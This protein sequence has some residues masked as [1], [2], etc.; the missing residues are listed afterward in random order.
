[1]LR[2]NRLTSKY[3]FAF[4]ICL[5]GCAARDP[6]VLTPSTPCR[7]WVYCLEGTPIPHC[8][9]I[10][11]DQLIDE[12]R[13]WHLPELVDLGL[14]NSRQTQRSWA[15]TRIRASEYGLSLADFYP[16]ISFSGYIEAVRATTYFG[17]SRISELPG[18]Q[19]IVVNEFRE[20][21]P[22]FSLAYLIFDWGT[23]NARSETFRQR[24][25]SANWEFNREIQTVIRQITGDYYSYVGN[26]GL[27][28]AA[29]ANLKDAQTLYDATHKKY[30]LGIVDKS[31]DL[32][33]LTQ[34]SKQQIQFLQAQQLLETSYAQL[35]AD[36]GIPSTIELNIFGQFE[37]GEVIFPAECTVEQCVEEA[38]MS[39]PDLFASYSDMQST[40]AAVSA[41]KRDKLPKVSLQAAGSRIYY[42]D[43]ENDGNDYGAMISLDYPIF[44]G[45]W[46]EN[47][48]RSASSRYC[49]AKADFEQLQIE[50]VK[51]VVIAHRDL[52]IAVE[53]LKVNRVYVDAAAES[54]RATLMQ[55]EAGVVDITTV[56]NAF[57]SLADARYSLVEAQKVWYTSI[58][59]LAYAIGILGKGTR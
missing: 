30:S 19:D 42:Q 16:E 41:A 25:L 13:V 38:L 23:R 5:A 27:Q 46:Y 20:Y 54:Y 8:Q 17:S 14:K 7:E 51:E 22:S 15:E 32:I 1:M 47:R 35:V 10:D 55:F 33:A 11:D 39:R 28:E 21:A 2:L 31:T 3:F 36:L 12:E 56:V 18:I 59:N 40:E 57:T 29:E 58:A 50:V 43:G 49:K 4:G 45:Y 52:E 24:V 37:A 9:L 26:K 6:F 53:N 34:V 44:K 48:I